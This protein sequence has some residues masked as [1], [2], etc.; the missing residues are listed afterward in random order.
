M[1]KEFYQG[2]SLYSF[3]RQKN[4][5]SLIYFRTR[6]P[7]KISTNKR[8]E[9]I[10]MEPLIKPVESFNYSSNL[11]QKFGSDQNIEG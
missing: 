4:N 5:H 9:I 8:P 11:P 6:V 2:Q 10:I 1:C 7:Y 3:R